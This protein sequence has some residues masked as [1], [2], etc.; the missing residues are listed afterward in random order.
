MLNLKFCRISILNNRNLLI[1]FTIFIIGTLLRLYDL[2]KQSFWLDEAR[3]FF[4]ANKSVSELWRGQ[5]NESNPPLYDIILH[6]YLK[7]SHA[8]DEG[9]IRMLSVIFGIALIPFSYFIGR[10]IFS[11]KGG[12]YFALLI[13]ISPFHI[14]YSQDAKMYSLLALLSLGSFFTY[15]LCF[16]KTNLAYWFLYASA[17]ILLIYTHNYGAFFYF[18]QIIIFILLFKKFRAK[19]RNFLLSNLLILFFIIPRI[20]YLP[21]QFFLDYNPWIKHPQISDIFKMLANFILLV[22][23]MQF[24]VPLSLALL[25][26]AM[27]FSAALISAF[28]SAKNK[29]NGLDAAQFTLPD[30]IKFIGCHFFIPLAIALLLSIKKPVYVSGRYDMLV[31]PLFCLLIAYGFSSIKKNLLQGFFIKS[32]VVL[33]AVSLYNYYFVFYK[34]ND[35]K[36]SSFIMS[37]ATKSDILIFTDLSESAYN[38]YSKPDY[39]PALIKF[40]ESNLGWLPR[41]AFKDQPAY[42][43]NELQQLNKKIK[44]LLKKDSKIWL[45]CTNLNLNNFLILVLKKNY[46]LLEKVDFPT[47]SNSNQIISAYI[48][49]AAE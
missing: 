18:S 9:S 11:G 21:R 45:M 6:F 31:F 28:V 29:T 39:H 23:G 42:I 15:Y 38:F 13:A 48:F 40:P 1:L 37:K 46:P 41:A 35:R 17:T 44:P 2:G 14:Y 20:I 43:I 49:N 34:S 8:K 7:F 26:I 22:P 24:D 16:C 33:T 19:T 10:Y 4:R 12:L 3:G 32:I 5:I 27:I 36:V 47:G 30:K 25:F